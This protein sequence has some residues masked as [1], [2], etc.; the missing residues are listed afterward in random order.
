MMIV[1]C[2]RAP[3]IKAVTHDIKAYLEI[4]GSSALV[5]YADIDGAAAFRDAVADYLSCDCCGAGSGGTAIDCITNTQRMVRR[6][7]HLDIRQDDFE[8]DYLCFLLPATAAIMSQEL[9]GTGML[10]GCILSGTPFG[11]SVLLRR[12]IY[13]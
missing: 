9:L 5:S 7:A 12:E 8:S 3:F 6:H 13:T 10:I 1:F 4:I 11:V 2:R